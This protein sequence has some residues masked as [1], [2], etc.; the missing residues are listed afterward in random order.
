M[1]RVLKPNGRLLLIDFG[2]TKRETFSLIGH[3][4]AHRDFDVLEL[5]PTIREHE[6]SDLKTGSLGFSDLQFIMATRF[7]AS[8]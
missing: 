7:A 5:I 1:A 3:L 2:G 6:F 8:G 4:R